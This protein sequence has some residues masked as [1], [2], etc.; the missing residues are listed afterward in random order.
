MS[1]IVTPL[2]SLAK[3]AA[4]GS[5]HL[6]DPFHQYIRSRQRQRRGGEIPALR[7]APA[8]MTENGCLT[9]TPVPWKAKAIRYSSG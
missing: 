2:K 1:P 3:D 6:C 9:P 4:A 5:P 7:F 8:G